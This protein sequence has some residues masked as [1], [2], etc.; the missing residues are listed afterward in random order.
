[1][2]DGIKIRQL[3]PETRVYEDDVLIIDSINPADNTASYT[4]HI[5][6]SDFLAGLNVDLEIPDDD[7]GGS[8]SDGDYFMLKQGPVVNIKVTVGNKSEFNRFYDQGNNSC[9]FLNGEEAPILMM[10]SG[11]TYRFDTTDVPSGYNFIFASS[12][13]AF[14][15]PISTG[16]EV[17]PGYIQYTAIDDYTRLYYADSSRSRYMGNAMINLD[18][19]QEWSPGRLSELEVKLQELTDKVNELSGGY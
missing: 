1:M 10:T 13:T 16:V 8:A 14:F 5:K 4:K 17:G 6:Y 2:A 19:S 15:G 12:I 18:G 3:D 9:Y 7:G 11:R